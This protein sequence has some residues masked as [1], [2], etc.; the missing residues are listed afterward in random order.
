ME[1]IDKVDVDSDETTKE[2]LSIEE[3][4]NSNSDKWWDLKEKDV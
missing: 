1:S 3:G 2:E 4:D